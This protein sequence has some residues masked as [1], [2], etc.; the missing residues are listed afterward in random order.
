MKT[1]ANDRIISF[2]PSGFA[3]PA[4]A[5]VPMGAAVLCDSRGIVAVGLNSTAR[6]LLITQTG[7]ARAAATYTDVYNVAR[8]LVVGGSC[9]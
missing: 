8:P 2:G 4:G 7:R 6:A 3:N 5:K 9:P 1:D